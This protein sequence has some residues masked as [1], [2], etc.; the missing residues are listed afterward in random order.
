MPSRRAQ[1][2]YN[3]EL[4]QNLA[5]TVWS[6]GGCHSWYMDEHGVNRT[7]WSGMTWQYWLETR[8]FQSAEYEFI[9]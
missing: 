2:E 9:R 6:T 4:Q 8:K 3:A 1:D 7:L 5:G